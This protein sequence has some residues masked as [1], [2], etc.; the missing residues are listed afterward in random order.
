MFLNNW[1]SLEKMKADFWPGYGNNGTYTNQLDGATIL[2]A[3]YGTPD[4][5]GY[6]FVLF[7]RGGKL[8][9]VDG[10]HCSCH[11]LEEQWEPEE[12][13]VAEL[14]HRRDKGKLGAEGYDHNP[15]ADELRLVLDNIAM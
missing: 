1:D 10:S 5:A 11:G 8:Y 14:R 9:E 6:A 4:Y 3:S 2:L 15:F 7:E 13:T 12:T